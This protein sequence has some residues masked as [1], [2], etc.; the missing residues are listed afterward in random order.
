LV[1]LETFV[2][3]TALNY[4]PQLLVMIRSLRRQM[5]D[6][7]IWVLC[8]DDEIFD[9][10]QRL[11]VGGVQPRN[12]RELENDELR[13]AREGRTLGEYCWTV[14]PFA[15]TIV[16][17]N[18]DAE[19]VTYVDAD[20]YFLKSPRPIL[21]EFERSGA[22]ALIT[23]HAFDAFYDD[24]PVV[25]NYCV[26]FMPFKRDSSQQIL[27][28]WQD[29]CIDWCFA[30]PDSGRLGDQKYLDAW[31]GRYGDDVHVLAE[32]AWAQG[33]WNTS[34][35]PHS[36]AVFFHM[37]GLRFLGRDRLSLGNYPLPR[38]TRQYVYGAYAREFGEVLRELESAGYEAQPQVSGPRLIEYAKMP[39]RWLKRS[40]EHNSSNHVMRF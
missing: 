32:G 22:A 14:T 21:E 39:L 5:P 19:V 7:E 9:L 12:L 17:R 15:P 11:R 34:R 31:P 38:P 23:P 24:S 33:P 18:S 36:E 10:L 3:V 27:R 26:Q 16:F 40:W 37:M 2:T 1:A 20:L 8:V 30:S 28:A 4:A 25:G 6:V 29:E 35:F 13:K